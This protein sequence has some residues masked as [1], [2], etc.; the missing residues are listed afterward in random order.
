MLFPANVAHLALYLST[1]LRKDS[2]TAVLSAYSA[3]KWIHGF[4]PVQFNPLDFTICK[5]LVETEKRS[6]H[7]PVVKKEPVDLD[8]IKSI[9]NNYASS[10]CNLKATMSTLL[11]V[12]LFRSQELLDM[13][14]CDLDVTDTYLEVRLPKSKT[15]IYRLGQAVFIPISGLYTCPYSLLIRY[16]NMS[17]IDLNAKSDQ[18]VFRNVV[19]H[20]SNRIFPR[21]ENANSPS[22]CSLEATRF[23]FVPVFMSSEQETSGSLSPELAVV[24]DAQKNAILTAVNAQIQGLQTNLLQAQSDLAFQIA[25]DLQPDTYVFKK[26]GN[27]QQFSFNRKVAKTSGT[28][29]KALESG[30]I[31]KAKEELNKDISLIN[32]RQKIIKLA[33]KSEFGWATV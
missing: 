25:S 28:A 10:D 27:E 31:P 3:L 33:D 20:K 19:Y 4:I 17:K 12:G 1:L 14:L 6:P 30:N 2:K 15:D 16:L 29:L 7:L 32:A 9:I 11:Y 8:M 13:T 26:K 24:L 18:F 23:Y 5:N 21:F 22:W